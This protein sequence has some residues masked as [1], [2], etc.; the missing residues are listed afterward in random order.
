M[1]IQKKLSEVQKN[2]S[3]PKEHKNNFG[4][5]KYRNCE[6]ILEALKPFL[7]DCT[8]TLS[9][10]IV[11]VQDRIYVKSTATFADNDSSI[12]V[13]SYARED[14]EKKGM[15]LSQ[16]TGSCSSYARKYALSGLFLIDNNQD[17]DSMDNTKSNV[18]KNNH[19]KE[20]LEAALLKI[21]ESK[22]LDELKENYTAAY[23]DFKDH[24]AM[25]E[26]TA[27]KDEIKSNI[28]SSMKL[29]KE[30]ETKIKE[31]FS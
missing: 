16:L 31:I 10:D 13:S 4:N 24:A 9:D 14:K 26:I 30:A 7:N 8:V 25:A 19:S 1:N 29:N 22:T 2:M 21:K 20:K 11:L 18:V 23:K 15:D 6:D 5:Y 17:V 3:V 28:E 12:S 27:L